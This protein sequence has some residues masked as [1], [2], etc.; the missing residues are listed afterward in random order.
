MGATR[1]SGN[2]KTESRPVSGIT[3]VELD[4]SGDLT[5]SRG[6]TESLTIEAEDNLLPLLTS[7]VNGGT[8]KLATK[9]GSGLSATKPIKYTLVVKNLAS[10]VL[11]ASGS[12]TAAD[13]TGGDK[14]VVEN[15]GS[16]D[17][18]LAAVSAGNTTVNVSGSG[19]LTITNLISTKTAVKI[20]GSG[21]ARVAGTT[22]DQNVNIS[23][24]GDFNADKLASKTAVITTNGSGSA[25]VQVSDTLNATISGS[26]DIIYIGSPTVTQKDDGSGK[27]TQ[28]S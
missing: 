11:N 6:E 2:L 24:S 12:I 27:I 1:G 23:G 4:T 16:G 3:A 19:A 20:D 7:D 28:Q 14:F 22:T 5:L 18:S 9:P 26:G 8:L 13:L 17:I 25:T 15:S 10:L 21:N